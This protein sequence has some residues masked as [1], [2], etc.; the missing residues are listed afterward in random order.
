MTHRDRGVAHPNPMAYVGASGD[1]YRC[2]Y[3]GYGGSRVYRAEYGL[4]QRR[5]QSGQPFERDE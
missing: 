3:Y 4:G 1:L 2:G 5:V